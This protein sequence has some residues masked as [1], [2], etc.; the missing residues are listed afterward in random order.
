MKFKDIKKEDWFYK[1]QQNYGRQRIAGNDICPICLCKLR[2]RYEGLVCKTSGCLLYFKLEKGWVYL[3]GKKKRSLQF[4]KD[5]YDFN[6]ENYENQ[7]KWL[8]LKVQ[9]F[10]ERDRECEIC[11]DKI[12]LHVHHIIPR[13][14]EPM[15]AFDKENLMI[16]CN[17]CHK[18]IHKEDKY[19][20]SK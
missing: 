3:D 17:D 4:L 7:K 8:K 20:F 11:T 14:K 12:E 19:K 9:I 16:V 1:L 6:I 2:K 13:S 10:N 5:K 15:L 18:E